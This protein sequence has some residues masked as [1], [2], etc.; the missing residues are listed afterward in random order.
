MEMWCF[1]AYIIIQKDDLNFLE[2]KIIEGDNPVEEIWMDKLG[3]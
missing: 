2:R 3:S 1:K